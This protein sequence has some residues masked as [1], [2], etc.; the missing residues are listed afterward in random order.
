MSNLG[1]RRPQL[2]DAPTVS[3]A[4]GGAD[5]LQTIRHKPYAIRHA[6]RLHTRLMADGGWFPVLNHTLSAQGDEARLLA[7][8]LWTLQAL[9]PEPS[10]GQ[11]RRVPHPCLGRHGGLPLREPMQ[12]RLL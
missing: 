2:T 3:Y 1:W 8:G 7:F 4:A 9:R 5:G 12:G 6:W 11:L 10:R